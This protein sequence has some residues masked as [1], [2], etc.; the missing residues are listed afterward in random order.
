MN[1]GIIGS[2]NRGRGLG[3][4]LKKIT[5]VE[6]TALCDPDL[7][8]LNNLAT[9]LNVAQQ[10]RFTDYK[11]ML[12]SP[13]FDA[14]IITSPD[15]THHQI[16]LDAAKNKKHILCEKPMATELKHCVEM[17][18]AAKDNNIIFMMGFCLRYNNLYRRAKE[19]VD[20]GEIG[21]VKLAYVVDSVERG[22]AYF[23]HDWHRLKKN[24]GGLLLQKGTHS[25][26]ILN[27]LAG[28]DPMSVYALGGLDVFGGNESDTKTCSA[29][30]KKDSC[31]E[32]INAECVGS[33][34]LNGA[35]L[36]IEDKCVYAREIDIMDNDALLI[37]Y[38][39]GAKASYV[40]CHFTPD[41]K[42]EFS[43]VGDKGRMDIMDYYS[44][45]GIGNPW[46]EIK[47]SKRHSRE[48]VTHH[49]QMR[50]GGHGGGD[51]LML[52]DFIDVLNGK[53]EKPVADGRTG[54][55]STAVAWAGEMSISTGKVVMI[56]DLIK[57]K[58]R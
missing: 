2:G 32:F 17:Q 48:T 41:Y 30:E 50:E 19:I 39:N 28:S 7:E 23:F 8:R 57:N 31:P 18:Q 55:L 9:D 38:E 3:I 24:S 6:I 26:D 34:Y 37:R 21:K 54:L 27:W 52:E 35:K 46:H 44:Q 14:V 13:L 11:K 43:I 56:G 40:E 29:C 4:E 45:S 22:S 1:I 47:V 15:H 42:R 16:V 12:L 36:M 51:S 33:D 25:L 49:V 53:K 58:E 20:S 10:G 5:G